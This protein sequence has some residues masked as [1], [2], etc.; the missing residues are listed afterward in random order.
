M[1]QLCQAELPSHSFRAILHMC[2]N[3]CNNFN[4]HCT[5]HKQKSR[6]WKSSTVHIQH[7]MHLLSEK[8]EATE[9]LRNTLHSA[10]SKNNSSNVCETA[11]LFK[12]CLSS[13]SATTL[14][15]SV[16]IHESFGVLDLEPFVFNFWILILAF[17]LFTHLMS[18]KIITTVIKTIVIMV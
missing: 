6:K 7:S 17:Q 1:L 12:D 2:I 5:N 15:S 11:V 13:S 9:I 14:C 18:R 3:D 10:W 16:L 8:N 4:I